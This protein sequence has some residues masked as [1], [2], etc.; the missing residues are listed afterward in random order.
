MILFNH[1]QKKIRL[2]TVKLRNSQSIQ[3]YFLRSLRNSTVH[4]RVH[5]NLSLPPARSPSPRPSAPKSYFLRARFNVF[6]PQMLRSLS[7]SVTTGFRREVYEKCAL[8]SL[9]FPYQ[10]PVHNSF[11]PLTTV[12]TSSAMAHH[13]PSSNCK[14]VQYTRFQ[15]TQS[16]FCL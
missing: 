9:G 15:P 7:L 16:R 8:L 10:N 12:R 1:M 13:I 2:T 6:L 14:Y 3:K 11:P 4:H 5:N